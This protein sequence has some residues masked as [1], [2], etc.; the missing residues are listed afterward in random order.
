M[1]A[2]WPSVSLSVSELR[3]Q[4]TYVDS[5][6]PTTTRTDETVYASVIWR[7]FDFGG[8]SATRHSAEALLEAALASEDAT[9]QK[10]LASAVQAFFDA[11]TAKAMQADKTED[12]N[13]ARETVATAE[14]KQIGGGAPQ[15]DVLQAAT[16][17]ARVSLDRNRAIGTYQKSL[18]ILGYTLGTPPDTAFDVGEDIDARTGSEEEDLKTWLAE[19]QRRH[20][21][22]IAARA[23]LDAAHSQV[24]ATRATGRP[25]ID[26]TANYYQN[27]F[28]NQGLTPTNTRVSTVGLTV[29]LPLFDGF[30]TRSRVRGAEA[31][32]KVKEAE[33]QDTEQAILMD[34]VKAY[35]DV[36]SSLRNL[37]ASEDLLHTAE[38]SLESSQRRY[39]NGA[40]DI[41]ELLNTQA[42]LV[43]AR[44]ERT[45]TLA[46]W[47]AAR[48]V[49][50]ARAGLLNRSAVLAK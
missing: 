40:A 18:A 6:Q 9:I 39:R 44:S 34:I 28:P 23:A 4:T 16:A 41:L 33:L 14:R 43:D 25:T 24:T 50:L 2:Y 3:D 46:E 35:A 32:V 20:P 37:T 31:T 11:V 15:S 8:R 19:A 49:L 42:A 10:T 13:L 45:R 22:I 21:A 26:F 30:A 7:L 27:G 48:L 17:L 47:R 29:N 38:A 12:E 1:S 5:H 36:Q